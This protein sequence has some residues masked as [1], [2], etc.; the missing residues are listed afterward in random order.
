M[1]KH[2]WM[3]NDV[4]RVGMGFF[5]AFSAIRFYLIRDVSGRAKQRLS[6]I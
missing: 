2:N 4:E 1:V 3:R 5:A 6:I